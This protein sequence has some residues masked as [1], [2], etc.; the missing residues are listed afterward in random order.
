NEPDWIE[1]VKMYL[2]DSF[3]NGAVAV[4]VCNDAGL[5]IKN[6]DCE[7]IQISE[8]EHSEEKFLVVP[9]MSKGNNKLLGVKNVGKYF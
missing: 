6:P 5:E 4:K 1:R 9:A 8:S 3:D 2:E 7:F